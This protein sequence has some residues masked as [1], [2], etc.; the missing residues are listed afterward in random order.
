MGLIDDDEIP[1]RGDQVV[2]ALSV[3]F[4]HLL[5]RPSA[6][7]VDGLDRVHGTEDLIAGSPEVLL[8]NKWPIDGKV[9]RDQGVK[10]LIEVGA[11]FGYPLGHK[12]LWGDHKGASYQPRSLSWR[13][14]S[15]ASIVLPNPT[16]SASR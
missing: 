13:R 8:P 6:A 7:S 11:H 1:S 10:L 14:I 3:I 2:K 15:P 12:P 4:G 16:S 5:P 9:A